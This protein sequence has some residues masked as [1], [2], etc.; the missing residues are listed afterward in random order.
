[1]AKAITLT[2][3]VSAPYCQ[4]DRRG[5]VRQIGFRRLAQKMFAKKISAESAAN[6]PKSIAASEPVLK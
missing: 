6:M 2:S 4:R 3:T 5:L 1:M